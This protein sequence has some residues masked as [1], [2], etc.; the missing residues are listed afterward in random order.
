MRRYTLLVAFFA[1]CAAP[2]G[3]TGNNNNNGNPVGNVDMSEPSGAADLSMSSTAHDLAMP[4][5]THDLAMPPTTHDLAGVADLSTPP[6]MS[7]VPRINEIMTGE[8]GAATAEFV[9]MYNPCAGTVALDGWKLVY[10]AGTSTV[11]S[12]GSDSATLFSFAAGT[13]M[14]AGKFLVYAGAG[15]TGT[16]DGALA[17]SLKDGV[18][19]VGLRDASGTLV[20][21]VGYGTVDAANAF[22]R[23]SAAQAPPVVAGGGSI[24]RQPDGSDS[25]DNFTD[26]K[27]SSAITPGAANH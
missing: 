19:A 27:L 4:P 5:T 20:D 21:S 9:E 18:G 13:Q 26:F 22:T 11:P 23:G 24:G 3:P 25:G 6:Q 8:P 7:C 10:R 16:T 15:F 17:G 1:G 2:N 14:T 12:S